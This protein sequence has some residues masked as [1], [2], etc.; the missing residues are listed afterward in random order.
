MEAL[1]NG[2]SGA[3]DVSA[4]SLE[5][6][7]ALVKTAV[8]SLDAKQP[9]VG[10]KAMAASIP[11]VIASDQ[12]SFPVT[13]AAGSAVIGKVSIDQTTPGTTNGVQVN[14]ALPAGANVIGHVINDT[15][16]TTAVTGNVTVVQGTGTNLHAVIDSG[17]L[18]TVSTVT[19]VAAVTAITNALPT[20]ANTIGSVNGIQSGTWTVQPG[21]TA[22]TTAWLT[23]MPKATTGTMSSVAGSA[24]SVTILASNASRRG[25]AVFN[26]SSAILYLAVSAT[27]ASTTAY[28]VQVAANSYYELPT[29]RLY[30]GQ[31]TGIWASATGSARVTEWS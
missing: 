7:Q 26:D 22:N 27:T 12:A 30:T 13:V 1:V 15:G 23:D 24:S 6:T 29:N 11:V 28:T 4:L 14:A 2:G 18:T 9:T 8:Q 31:L 3:T 5:S 10:Q 16:S 19:T 25:A 17:T 21:N 20:G